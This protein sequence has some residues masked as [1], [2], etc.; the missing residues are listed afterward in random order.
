M[1]HGHAHGGKGEV[2]GKDY[3]AVPAVHPAG[4]SDSAS[5]HGHT[6]ISSTTLMLVLLALVGLTILTVGAALVENF[7][8]ETF[9]VQPEIATAINVGVCLLIATVKTTLVVLFFMQLKYDNPINGMIFIFTLLTV[10]TF[11]GFTMLD[12]GNRGT[13]DRFKDGYVHEGGTGIDA[14][15]YAA[16][17][18]DP[19]APAVRPI[20]QLARDAAIINQFKVPHHHHGH[21][22]PKSPY[23]NANQS[24]PRVG[25]TEDEHEEDGH[26]HH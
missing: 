11:L 26:D 23:S 9:H 14:P 17:K 7:I 24:R 25:M 5:H 15:A 16:A 3:V 13:I 6:I 12:L 4:A 2:H 21:G 1:A 19:N 20:T 8:V 22:K 10:A 18:G